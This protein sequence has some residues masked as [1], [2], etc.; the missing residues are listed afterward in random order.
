M[1]AASILYGVPERNISW[2]GGREGGKESMFLFGGPLGSEV[3][4]I[5]R[6]DQINNEEA[7][8]KGNK[9]V[10]IDVRESRGVR[11]V[12]RERVPGAE[13]AG[14]TFMM[15]RIF[16]SAATWWFLCDSRL[17]KMHQFD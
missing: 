5:D 17:T 15:G 11:E 1:V 16:S 6:R 10:E 12:K 13:S 3:V 8:R 4:G 7:G 14:S 9:G 2:V